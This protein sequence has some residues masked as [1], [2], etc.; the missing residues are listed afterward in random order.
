MRKALLFAAG[1]ALLSGPAFA[2]CGGGGQNSGGPLG[3]YARCG[4]GGYGYGGYYGGYGYYAPPAYYY[5]P[6][7]YGGYGY[8]PY[9]G[10]GG[11]IAAGIIGG[12]TLGALAARS[13]VH[14]P[15]RAH[16]RRVWRRW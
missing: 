15:R 7:Y 3:S 8:A 6:A 12:L 5:G 9:Y 13:H 4:Y 11:A 10:G 2:Q 16:H 14:F 1:F